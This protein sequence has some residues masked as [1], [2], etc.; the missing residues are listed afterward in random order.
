MPAQWTLFKLA[1]YIFLFIAVFHFLQ[2]LNFI[3]LV[4]P[5]G[6]GVSVMMEVSPLMLITFCNSIFS[7]HVARRHYP[8]YP[9]GHHKK[10]LF[11]VSASLFIIAQIV[12]IYF[13]Y[14]ILNEEIVIGGSPKILRFLWFNFFLHLLGGF[15]IF[16]NQL[17]LVNHI[18]KQYKRKIEDE[19]AE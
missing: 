1:N 8:D 16:T 18:N 9:M 2:L 3:V 5:Q 10:I 6:E 12:I 14:E 11:L 15:F 4:V 19:D 13:L 17:I 7:L